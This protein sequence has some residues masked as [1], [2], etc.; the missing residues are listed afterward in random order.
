M[1]FFDD[2]IFEYLAPRVTADY[3]LDGVHIPAENESPIVLVLEYAGK[4]SAY[5]NALLKQKPLD[6][7]EAATKRAATLFAK[8]AIAGW[9]N[10]ERDGKPVPYTPELGTEVLVK[11]VRAKRE[12]KVDAAVSYALNPDNFRA[13]IIKAADLGKL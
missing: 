6:D 1:S 9:K 4:G 13:P 11:L 5:W 12:G 7:A 8:H 3:T 2:D 10:V